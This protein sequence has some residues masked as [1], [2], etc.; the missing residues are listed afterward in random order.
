MILPM[1]NNKVLFLL[2]IWG[3][4]GGGESVV[5]ELLLHLPGTIEKVVV[6]FEQRG[7]SPVGSR[8]RCL[9]VRLS[10]SFI[11]KIWT[12]LLGYLRFRRVLAQE[13]PDLVL[14]FGNL[15]NSIALLS[16]T[17]S[18]VRVE[19][20][21]SQ[22]SVMYRV[23]LKMLFRRARKVLAVSKGLERD[24]TQNFR[25]PKEHIRMIYNPIDVKRIQE[26]S[27]E[28]LE[29]EYQKIFH[30]V[31][32][33]TMGSLIEQKGHWH[34]IRAFAEAKRKRADVKLILLGEGELEQGLKDLV[35]DLGVE[36]DVYFAGWQKNPFRF[37]AR[38]RLFVFPSLWEGLGMALLEALAC[39]L[40]VISS[41]CT[42]GPREILAPKTDPERRTKDIEY[43]QYGVLVPACEGGFPRA[44]VPLSPREALWERAMGEMLN[45]ENVRRSFA[46]K[47]RE[48]ARD[49]DVEK[50][51]PQYEGLLQ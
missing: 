39:G 36:D 22:G 31:A 7:S 23:I 33:I 14:S 20:P 24:L 21:P 13:K 45:Q 1:K 5:S 12:F 49:F 11:L 40:P 4:G 10:K 15:Q 47:A 29:E 9:D 2:P 17:S 25:I 32:I 6:P 27:R 16:Q 42:A 38:S 26:L 35:R 28:P 30:Q 37:L 34:L 41:D 48:R 18:I 3:G 44:D 19:N 50:I 51:I 46:E 8:I 43:G